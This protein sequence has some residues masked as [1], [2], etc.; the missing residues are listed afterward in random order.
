[1]AMSGLSMLNWG[2]HVFH[3]KKT[4]RKKN[5]VAE[6]QQQ[7]TQRFLFFWVYIP[8]LT[9]SGGYIKDVFAYF[10]AKKT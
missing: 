5:L 9:W 8:R 1:M 4:N 2:G 3:L 10:F 6:N 7:Q